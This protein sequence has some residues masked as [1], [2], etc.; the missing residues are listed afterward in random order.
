MNK[1][2]LK[3]DQVRKKYGYLEGWVSIV[4]NLILFGLK[5]WVGMISNSVAIMADAW[6][7]VSD[8]VTSVMIIAGFK[9]STK[10][11]D[12]E[13]PFGHGRVENI[14]SIIIATLLGTVSFNFFRE[15]IIKLRARETAVFTI[16]AVVVIAVSVIV[17]ELNAQLA[18]RLSKKIDSSAL[19]ADGWHHRSDAIT[20]VVIVISI[21]LGGDIWWLDGVL[22]I[23]ISLVLFHAVYD[24]L[25]DTVDSILGKNISLELKNQIFSLIKKELPE[26][27]YAH[28]FHVH[29][30]GGHKELTF[31]LCLE[32]DMNLT[33][34]H[35]KVSRTEKLIRDK[36][37]VEATVHIEPASIIPE[38]KKE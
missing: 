24:I 37:A 9:I 22:G 32:G 6:H 33:E 11:A 7:T 1:N 5:L 16:S 20:S 14:I 21:L 19:R 36:L 29:K 35:N 2:T 34:A 25:K 17:K 15:S 18:F 12:R 28:H 23:I 8:S 26:A 10:E 3:S 31:H 30:Y 13:H 4:I 38:D 27:K